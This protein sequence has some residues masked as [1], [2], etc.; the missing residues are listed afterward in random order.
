MN[1]FDGERRY[2]RWLR[3]L[4]RSLRHEAEGELLATFR[5]EHARIAGGGPWIRA[6]FWARMLADLL[7]T[8]I[9]ERWSRA[10]RPAL[11]RRPLAFLAYDGRD[12]WRSL[13]R[14]PGFTI[15]VVLTLALGTGVN[16]AIFSVVDALLFKS[17]PYADSDRLVRLAEWPRSGGNYTVAP[18]AFLNWRQRQHA[19][20]TLEAR[21]PRSFTWIGDGD[22]EELAGALVTAGYFDLLGVRAAYG[23]TF[24]GVEAID[25][26]SCRVVISHRRWTRRL[27]ADP[28]AIGRRL[29]F[30]GTR[31]ELL[32]VLPAESVFDR[33]AFDVYGPLVLRASDGQ[34]QGRILTVFGRLAPEVTLAA[35][36][37]DLIAVAASFNAERGPAGRGWTAAIT[38]MRDVLVR[39]PT[40]QLMWVLFGAVAVVLVVACVNVAGLSLS[41]TIDRRREIAVRAALGAGRWRLFRF[42]VVESLMLAAAGTAAGLV[43]GSWALGAFS[44]LVPPGVLPPEALAA[45]DLRT[46][47]FSSALAVVVG[48]LAGALPAWQAART[49][50]AP[51]LAASGRTVSGSRRTSQLQAAFVVIEIAMAMTLVTGAV[52]LV[53][54]FT[55]LTR[56]DPGFEASGLLTMRLDLPAAR[57]ADGVAPAVYERVLAAL[58]HIPD[59][60][61]VGAATSLPLGGWRF[62]T[63]FVVDGV[64]SDPDR[65]AS[66]HIQ[67]VA[68][69]YFETLGIPVATGRTFRATDDARAPLVAIVNETFVRRFIQTVPGAPGVPAGPG[70]HLTLGIPSAS[71]ATGARWE[72]VGVIRDVKTGGLADSALATPEIYVSHQQ[73]PMTTMFLAA[74]SRQ[75]AAEA[76]LPD[77]RAALRGVDSQLAVSNVMPMDQRLGASVARQQFQMAMISTFGV[78][79][80]VV[81]CL[82]VYAMRSQSVRARRRELGIRLALGATRAQVVR[83]VLGQTAVVVSVGL[84]LGLG[85][86]LWM[87]RFVESWLFTTRAT[88]PALLAIAMLLLGTAAVLA[89]WG[90]A[91]RAGRVDPLATLRQD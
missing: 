61:H 79:A 56:V 63:T 75:G 21:L 39:P 9:A 80:T 20:S 38:P 49:P 76:L 8:S 74:R 18:A 35:A 13:Q 29:E 12:A 60:A 41:R 50:A 25:A 2:R 24:T 90:P 87:T 5:R 66:A 3:L 34:Q 22:P 14:T 85:G 86:A 16:A 47:A 46:L 83:L 45:M 77:I 67:H 26:D 19:F 44:A 37:A 42:L 91:R 54:S 43:I 55:R 68:G 52:L 73:S 4:P 23:R 78:L 69:D 28:A 81:A 31:C 53:V 65:P 58:A 17:L 70:R 32:G 48:V 40:R 72:I 7:V 71:G 64:P 1:A 27:A 57:Y 33:I 15:V 30:A 36:E 84:L 11:P 62:G 6:R 89:S 10:R 51:A 88:E 59:V 82:G